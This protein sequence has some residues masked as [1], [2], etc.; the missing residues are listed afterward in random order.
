MTG[1]ADIIAAARRAFASGFD[2]VI[3]VEPDDAPALWIDGRR[4]PPVILRKAPPD[5]DA[6]GAGQCLWRGSRETLLRIFEGER[7]LG[8]A[9][10][11]GR[12]AIGG[13]MSVMARLQ[14]E[15]PRRG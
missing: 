13:D 12:L 1:E 14:L 7:L 11:S 6:N 4:T 8:S 10:L 3:R 2:G 15:G 5:L 9:Y